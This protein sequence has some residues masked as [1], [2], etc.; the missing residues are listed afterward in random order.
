MWLGSRHFFSVHAQ[1]GQVAD[2]E[3]DKKC[4]VLETVTDC[5]FPSA[6][7]TMCVETF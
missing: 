1:N 5:I 6:A 2:R 4:T 7:R 3:S